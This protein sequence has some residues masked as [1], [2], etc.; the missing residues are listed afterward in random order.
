VFPIGEMMTE[1]VG[2]AKQG[3][4]H[5]AVLWWYGGIPIGSIFKISLQ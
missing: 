5:N 4:T 3:S 1:V 2:R